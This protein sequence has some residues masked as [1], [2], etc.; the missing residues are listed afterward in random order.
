V[1]ESQLKKLSIADSKGE[2]VPPGWDELRKFAK[3][4]G[5]K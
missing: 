1:F 3:G 5:S 4:D 2:A